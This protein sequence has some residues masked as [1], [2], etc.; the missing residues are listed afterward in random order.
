MPTNPKSGA[1][2]KVEPVKPPPLPPRRTVVA[3][4]PTEEPPKHTIDPSRLKRNRPVERDTEP[5]L[6][7]VSQGSIDKVIDYA[8]NPT[9][10]K[11]REMTIID[12]LQARLLP[13]LDLVNQS[14]QYIIEVAMVRQD[15]VEYER[16]FKRKRPI[17]PNPIE[18]YTYRMAQW[19][20]S[21]DGKNLERATD[22]ALAE[23]ETRGDDGS[24]VGGSDVWKDD[25]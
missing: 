9:R 19:Q 24:D 16:L 5:E 14:W 3:S 15:S 6:A 8:F 4:P 2:A 20:K 17:P 12:R 13:Q 1:R 18:E 25:K 7:A 22:I 21:R 10:D 11:I 23:T